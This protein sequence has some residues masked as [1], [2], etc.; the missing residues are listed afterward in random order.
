MHA[1]N[2]AETESRFRADPST[3]QST[4]TVTAS[5]VNGRARLSAGPFNWD[6][7]LPAAL[8]GE[9]LAPSPTAYLLG[10]LAGCGVAFLHDTLAPQFGVQ[11]DDVTAVAR[12]SS[13]ARGLIGID[14]IAPD[15]TDLALEIKVSSPSPHDRIDAMLAAWQ[16]RCPIYLALLKPNAIA[17]TA[18]R[19][20]A[21][22]A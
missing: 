2:L 11:I 7:D 22:A 16:E 4:P 21:A 9:N 19:V 3:A 17:L 14:E 15:L 20:D 12:A 1:S 10:A 8:G 18:G 13:D 5:L 6:A